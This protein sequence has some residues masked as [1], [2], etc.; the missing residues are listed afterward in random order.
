MEITSVP[1]DMSTDFTS[2]EVVQITTES[3]K[4]SVPA[5]LTTGMW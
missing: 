2:E 1:A 4:T 3:V 5:E